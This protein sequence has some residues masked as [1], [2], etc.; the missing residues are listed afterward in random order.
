MPKS[1]DI[2]E[3]TGDRAASTPTGHN[4]LLV[5]AIDEYAHCPKLSNCVKDAKDLAHLLWERYL[6]DSAHTSFL[7]DQDA[8]RPRIL[9]AIKELRHTVGEQ[10]NLLIYFSGHGQTVDDTGY[11]I[12]V[13]AEADSEVD[14]I[15]SHDLKIRLDAIKSFH[16]LLIADACFSGSIFDSMLARNLL[17]GDY[18]KPS[19]MGLTASDSQELA[20]DGNVGDNSTFAACLLENLRNSRE[21]LDTFTLAANLKKDVYRKSEGKQTPVFEK[22]NIKGHQ[23]GQFVFK[24][25][26]ESEDKLWAEAQKGNS[27]VSFKKYLTQYPSGNFAK[28]AQEQ[29]KGL[30]EQEH[31]EKAKSSDSVLSLLDFLDQFPNTRF[32]QE[33]REKIDYLEDFQ[34]W[35]RVKHSGKIADLLEYKDSHPKGRFIEEAEQRL[36]A[37][38]ESRRDADAW[39]RAQSEHSASSY[40]R[41][42]SDFPGGAFVT[43]AT[44]ELNVLLQK[45]VGN[46][47]KEIE[48]AVWSEAKRKGRISNYEDYLSKFPS[49][50]YSREALEKIE[51]LK[52]EAVLKTSLKQPLGEVLER[53]EQNMVYVRGGTFTMG[54]TPEQGSDCYSD[55]KPA[56]QVTVSDFYIGKYE[57]TQKEWREVMGSDRSSGEK[58]DAC[59]VENVSWNDIQQFISKLNAK[60]GKTYRLPTE[61]EWEYAARGGSSSRGYKYAGSNSLNEVAWY[62]DNSG[63]KTHPVGQKKANELGLYDMSG[64][65]WE[66]CADWYGTYPSTAQTNPKGPSSGAS[67]RVFRGG[68]WGLNALL[69]R[70]SIRDNNTPSLRYVNLG[71]RLAL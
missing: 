19:R 2:L 41:Y 51:A 25:K 36:N 54:C 42:L 21:H 13:E 11:W 8:T 24:L 43:K 16:T 63:A 48:K 56:H 57:V 62:D 40:Q 20:Y 15:S 12:P 61:A 52:K 22:L 55:E 49:G 67:S 9:N 17:T 70:V 64:N 27:I 68:S 4:H 53:L 58:C 65:V 7:L 66:W 35:E 59:P 31:W 14:F 34:D 69:C 44:S 50:L 3:E 38:R 5:I 6:F 10:D 46:E 37:L 45:K 1:K 60:T 23:Q 30:E 39:Q 28:S 71:F 29:L 18:S 47:T 33:A 32:K 26:Q